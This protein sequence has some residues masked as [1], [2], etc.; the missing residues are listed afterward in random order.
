MNT[1]NWTLDRMLDGAYAH[2][3]YC[4]AAIRWNYVLRHPQSPAYIIVGSECVKT[5]TDQ[6]DPAVA[7]A[8][9]QGAWKQRRHYFYKRL[10]K[11]TYII[12][13]RSENTWF[14]ATS[15]S[16]VRSFGWTFEPEIFQTADDAKLALARRARV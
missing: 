12:G 4:G 11:T 1:K 13:P 15:L 2:C 6:C 5:L 14:A 3:Q 10:R 16:G 7:F 8:L 9:T